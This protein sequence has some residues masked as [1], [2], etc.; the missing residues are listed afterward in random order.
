MKELLVQSASTIREVL[1]EE[2]VGLYSAGLKEK[3]SNTPVVVAGIQSCYKSADE[4]GEFHLIVVD[5]AHLIP[6]DGAGRYRT[7]LEAER[8]VSPKAR[9]VGLTATP[10]RM[11]C[12]WIVRDKADDDSDGYDRLLD[13]IVYEVQVADLIADGTLSTVVSKAAK[14]A[15]D[16]SKVR[17]KRGEFDEEEIEKI[18]NKKNVLE[19]AC[20]EIVEQTQD[21]TKVLVFCNRRASAEKCARL[22]GEYDRDVEAAVV[23][24]ETSSGDRAELVRRFK[25][26]TREI[27]LFGSERKPLKYICNVGVFTTGFDAPNVD[28]VVLLRPTKSLSLYQQIVGRGLRRSPNKGNCLVLDYGGNVERHGPIDCPNPE[29]NADA[30]KKSRWKKCACGAIVMTHVQIC[31]L[32]GAEFPKGRNAPD[33]NNG[34]RGK[35]TTKSI[36]SNG[37]EPAPEPTVEEYDVKEVEYEPHWKKDADPDKPPT[38]QAKYSRG[39]F[40]RPVFEWLCPGHSNKWARSRFES[41]WKSKSKVD[42]PED[43]ETAAAWA[44][45]GA[46]AKPEKIRVVWVPGERFPKIEWLE[47]GEIPDFDPATVKSQEEQDEEFWEDFAVFDEDD[48]SRACERPDGENEVDASTAATLSVASHSRLECDQCRHWSFDEL[49]DARGFCSRWGTETPPE[50]AGPDVCFEDSWPEE[51]LP[52]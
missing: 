50:G 15:P 20:Q 27:D 43:A 26:L 3:T 8:T 6:P 25:G 24:G 16:F 12:G 46:L 44:N 47:F 1:G 34:L 23:D 35:A 4:L 14:K 37:D 5:E 38:F 17:V 45:A 36:L 42:P 51:D 29:Q 9:L 28:C 32:C 11:G 19:I 30:A 49:D 40:S 39:Q 7:L 33:P 18:L 21:R 52:F 41:W 13:E 10:Y 48:P 2:S 22:L 31:P